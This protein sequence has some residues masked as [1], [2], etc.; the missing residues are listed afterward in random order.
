MVILVGLS[1]R[2]CRKSGLGVLCVILVISTSLKGSSCEMARLSLSWKT[3]GCWKKKS[4]YGLA[5]KDS[6]PGKFD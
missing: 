6:P 4:I 1:F 2:E 3:E 5:L